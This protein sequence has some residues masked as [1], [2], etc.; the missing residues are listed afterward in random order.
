M[1]P[2]AVDPAQL[3]VAVDVTLPGRIA[4]GH[5]IDDHVVV[6]R[7]FLV[8]AF[9]RFGVLSMNGIHIPLTLGAT[10]LPAS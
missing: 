5:R 2:R 8:V 4:F 1:V 6:A 9:A 3:R 10:D 7:G